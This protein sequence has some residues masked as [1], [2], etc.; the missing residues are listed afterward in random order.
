M[1][2]CWTI[3]S[4]SIATTAMLKKNLL[5]ANNS[6]LKLKIWKNVILLR[7]RYSHDLKLVHGILKHSVFSLIFN[8]ESTAKV[9]FK[10]I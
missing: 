9:D 4:Q 2:S 6:W 5:R 7:L 1:C 8:E 10:Y 3:H